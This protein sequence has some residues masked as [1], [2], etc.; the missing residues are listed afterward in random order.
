MITHVQPE[1]L[2]ILNT[3]DK[4]ILAKKPTESYGKNVDR[5][6]EDLMELETTRP[7]E[8]N[9]LLTELY[10]T[11]SDGNTNKAKEQVS[12]LRDMIGEDPEI[13][14]A[15]VLIKRQEILGK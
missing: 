10:E 3:T 2:F 12:N 15:M 9:Y 5:V 8:V 1:D 4:G 6:L 7:D 11:I 13:A 14:K